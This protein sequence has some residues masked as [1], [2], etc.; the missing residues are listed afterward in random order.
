MD[1]I[2]M[3]DPGKIPE[4]FKGILI[5]E[6]LHLPAVAFPKICIVLLYLKVFT[7]KWAR[8]ATWALLYIIIATWISFF[9]AVMF[10]C[11]PFAYNWDK[12]IPEGRCFNIFIFGQSSSIPN[13]VTDAAVLLLPIRTVMELKISIGRRIGLLLIFLTGSV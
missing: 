7:N 1:Y 9:V 12:T 3:T 13:I 8:M 5:Q 10:Q 2:L 4:H 11:V 6:V